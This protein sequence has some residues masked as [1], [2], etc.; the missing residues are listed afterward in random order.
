MD[1]L[2]DFIL[3]SDDSTTFQIYIP[4]EKISQSAGNLNI[5][6]SVFDTVLSKSL[7]RYGKY[8][9]ASEIYYINENIYYKIVNRKD[10]TVKKI[11]N[12][13]VFQDKTFMI[14]KT[15]EETQQEADFPL[16]D[17]YNDIKKQNKMI[18]NLPIGKLN[19]ITQSYE[20]QDCTYFIEIDFLKDD[21]KSNEDIKS[22]LNE[23]ESI[24]ENIFLQQRK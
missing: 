13:D 1:N 16:I 10:I 23:I 18:F 17:R 24:S 21:I 20:D 9:K 22:L 5:E 4:T 14:V 3:A 12:S 8:T 11:V 19:L 2:K 7:E 6:K 15:K